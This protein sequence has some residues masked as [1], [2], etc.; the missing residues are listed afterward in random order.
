MKRT[1]DIASEICGYTKDKL[2]HKTWRWNKD[3]DVAV[4]RTRELLKIWKY[5]R[6]EENRKKCCEAKVVW[7]GASYDHDV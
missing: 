2:R 3:V 1:L 4:Y 7:G 5:S 6:N